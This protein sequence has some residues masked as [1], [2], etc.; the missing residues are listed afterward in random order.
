LFVVVLV[1]ARR[2]NVRALAA[3]EIALLISTGAI[4]LFNNAAP[5]YYGWQ[6]RGEWVARL[7]QPVFVVFLM[8]AARVLAAVPH[9]TLLRAAI[10]TVVVANAAIV[11]GPVTMTRLGPFAYHK[12]YEHS[13][14]HF[15]LDNLRKFGRRPL[16]FCD[17]SHA[18]DGGV[19][20]N[21]PFNR[22]V[23]MYRY[24]EKAP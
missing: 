10:V 18:N 24:E 2:A 11:F 19:D 14:E 6:M 3:P 21:T 20:P 1:I 16:G 15:F 22:P 12:F 4:F 7:Y 5:P 23:Y 9:S 13:P 17:P 8:A